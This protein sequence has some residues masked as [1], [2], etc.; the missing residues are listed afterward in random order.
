VLLAPS[1]RCEGVLCCVRTTDFFDCVRERLVHV[2]RSVPL[3]PYSFSFEMGSRVCGDGD[4]T[5]LG[6]LGLCFSFSPALRFCSF[7][8]RTLPSTMAHMERSLFPSFPS[9]NVASTPRASCVCSA[10]ARECFRRDCARQLLVSINTHFFLFSLPLHSAT[11]SP[12]RTSAPQCLEATSVS[13][14]RQN[15]SS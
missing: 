3:L 15:S 12:T 13:S 8:F 5:R 10:L 7:S 1:E 4:C 9:H 6:L 11:S 14:R 2:L